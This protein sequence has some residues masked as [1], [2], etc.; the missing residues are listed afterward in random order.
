MMSICSAT[1]LV[2]TFATYVSWNTRIPPYTIHIPSHVLYT[3]R[4]MLLKWNVYESG[5]NQ[6]I[7]YFRVKTNHGCT[8]TY[9]LSYAEE[10]RL[11]D[12][13]IRARNIHIWSI[14]A[15]L[16]QPRQVVFRSSEHHQRVRPLSHVMRMQLP[17][18]LCVLCGS[19]KRLNNL[20][21][22]LDL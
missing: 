11:H 10:T 16:H 12:W 14:Y 22:A 20:S 3:Q 18:L 5:S 6:L 15:F 8:F 13:M 21:S 7:I 4:Y 9:V 1:R 19:A 2:F 17:A